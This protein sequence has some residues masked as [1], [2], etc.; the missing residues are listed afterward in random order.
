M[1]KQER[2]E[3]TKKELEQV[4]GGRK[5]IG[6]LWSP[7]TGEAEPVG[8]PIPRRRRVRPFDD[9]PLDG[10]SVEVDLDLGK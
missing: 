5:A 7:K 10:G 2:D 1:K 4:V 9:D 6:V 8:R 3:L